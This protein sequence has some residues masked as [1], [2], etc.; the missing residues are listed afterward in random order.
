MVKERVGRT[1]VGRRRFVFAAVALALGMLPATATAQSSFAAA[2]FEAFANGAVYHTDAVQTGETRVTNIDEAF[3]GAAVDSGGL[4]GAKLNEMAR[5]FQNPQNSGRTYGRGSGLEVGILES[6]TDPTPTITQAA[7]VE[8][9]AGPGSGDTGLRQQEVGPVALDPIAYAS[10]LRGQARAQWSDSSCILGSDLSFGLGFANDTQLID[11]GGDPTPDPRL[12]NALIATDHPSPER[13]VAQSLSRT[14]LVPQTNQ[15]NQ[16]VGGNFGVL[17]ETRQ[18]IAPVTLF[19]NTPNALTIET[20]GEWVLQAQAGGVPGSSFVH[21]GPGTVSPETPILRTINAQNQVTNILTFQQITGQQGLVLN[22]PGIAEIAIGE[23][24]RAI[25]GDADSSPAV[26]D[27]FVSAAVDVLR[28]K[29][30]SQAPS[31]STSG[32]SVTDLRV[33]HMEV[34]SRVPAG[35]IICNLGVRKNA[36]PDIVSVGDTFTYTINVDNPFD[37]TLTN[38][39]VEDIIEGGRVRFV[40]EGA[41]PPE[42]SRT[43][44][45]LVW[46]NLPDVPPRSSM[47]PPIRVRVRVTGGSGRMV[48]IARA[49]ANCAVGTGRGQATVTV[50]VTGEVRVAAPEAVGAQLP[51]TG[52]P[53]P[54]AVIG[55]GA[56]GAALGARRLRRRA[57]EP[58]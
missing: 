29:L 15:A 18:T 57:S 1:R 55:L 2:D 11:T 21:Y 40:I 44:N 31:P 52:A 45:R 50:P 13:G 4:G 32:T 47:D 6:S 30:L 41:E 28:I 33:G 22:V 46:E 14:R 8:A 35:G 53:A 12:E 37:C 9:A 34:Q 27:T 36:D 25:N 3:S 5:P 10:L 49:T 19:A 58:S 17:A 24:P 56:L 23:D 43:G 51:A 16:V 26:S 7:I 42:S 54:L 38:V 39:R 48:D 20:L